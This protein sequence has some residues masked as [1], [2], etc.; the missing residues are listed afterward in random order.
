MTSDLSS[1]SILFDEVIKPTPQGKDPKDLSL[2]SLM[3]LL[4]TERL[5]YLE[6]KSRN[7]LTELRERQENVAN[8]NKVLKAINK[9]TDGEGKLDV[10]NDQELQDLLDT[11]RERGVEVA[12]GKVT[13]NREERNRLV[14]NIRMSVEDLNVENDMQLQTV[15]RLTNERHEMYQMARTILKPLHDAKISRARALAGR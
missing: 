11:A 10:S 13:F 15:T 3:V 14:E 9:T 2:E 7:E 6:K 1:Q 5:K 4:M 8:L 12:D